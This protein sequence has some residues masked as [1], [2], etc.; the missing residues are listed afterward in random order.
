STYLYGIFHEFGFTEWDNVADLLTAMSGKYI[1]S[2]THKLLKD[3]E[4]LLLS[5]RRID[6]SRNEV[7]TIQKE[8]QTTELPLKMKFCIVDRRDNNT[9][10]II[11]VAENA[12]K[13]PLVI[14]KW[15]KGDYFYPLGFHGK[16]KL[17]KFFK[18]EKIDVLSKQKQ[19]L[20]CSGNEIV[21]VIGSRADDR[22][23]V[24]ENT[25]EVLR[26]EV[27]L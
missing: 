4:F 24:K 3:R 16:K 26:I 23:K 10:D 25:K 13:Y 21:W 17:S 6:V 7:F 11:Y 8:Q 27:I 20:L 2:D 15:N 5:E 12:L 9:D 19:W 18:D 22:F 14:R 1:I